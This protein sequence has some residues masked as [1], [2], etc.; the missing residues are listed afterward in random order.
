MP[1]LILKEGKAGTRI[2][3]LD[4]E[5]TTIGRASDCDIR[6]DRNTV[7][8]HHAVIERK[9]GGFFIQD[10]GSTNGTYLNGAIIRERIL[11]DQDIIRIG[12][13]RLIFDE[14]PSE[15]ISLTSDAPLA[16]LRQMGKAIN[17]IMGEDD[18]LHM[19]MDMIFRVFRADRGMI[20]LLDG[21]TGEL[22]PR[23]VRGKREGE[24]GV[25]VSKT[26]VDHVMKEKLALIVYD[27]MSDPR[28][29]E[30]Q[31]IIASEVGSVMAVPMLVRDDVI[32]IIQVDS[33]VG[34][35]R[36]SEEELDLLCSMSD[37][38]A[39]G[40]EQARLNRRIERETKLRANLERFHS[41]EVVNKIISEFEE[42]GDIGLDVEEKEASVLFADICDFTS[43]S[44]E[45]HPAE[46][47]AL[48][49]EYFTLMTDIIFEHGGTLDKFIGD[50]VMALFGVPYSPERHADRAAETAKKM[51]EA[52]ETF[53][54]RSGG[55][56]KLFIRV[57]IDTG[58]VVA[59]NI[60]SS[61]RMEYT[62]LGDAVNTAS[63][64]CDICKPGQILIGDRTRKLLTDDSAVTEIGPKK[65]KGKKKEIIVHE[66]LY[67]I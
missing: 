38:L 54:K 31:S 37:Y 21:N 67:A 20:L 39:I 36:F 41:P 29:S 25:I 32:G 4:R 34:G 51:Q 65:V 49:N 28:F 30:R 57:G 47:T 59:G 60:G 58:M 35:K 26:L 40:I 12:G 61:K 50:A 8:R 52:T 24:E 16:V 19:V 66:L 10:L 7:S 44:E 46:V 23:L 2:F 5:R 62:V 64:L 53:R 33:Y 14:A 1:R 56:P 17:R 43:I 9:K 13:V 55:A 63:R 22:V 45:L 27:T 3:P 48:L 42:R 15:S 18:I 6:M 11:N